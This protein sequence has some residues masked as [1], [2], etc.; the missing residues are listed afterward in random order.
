MEDVQSLINTLQEENR[1]LIAERDRFK[2][3]A[4]LYQA[5]AFEEKLKSLTTKEGYDKEREE[6]RR[7]DREEWEK[8]KVKERGELEKAWA[9][10][11]RRLEQ[12]RVKE[13]DDA[14]KLVEELAKHKTPLCIKPLILS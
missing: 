14:Q 10:E 8:E 3:L 12:A 4:S 13:K 2:K 1:A 9:K 6:Q 5:E 7:R 11:K